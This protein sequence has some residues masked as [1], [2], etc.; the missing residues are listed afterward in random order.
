MMRENIDEHFE[1]LDTRFVMA[2]DYE[3]KLLEL[4]K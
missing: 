3:R 2:V 1:F 4:A